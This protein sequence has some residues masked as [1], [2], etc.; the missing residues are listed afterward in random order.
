MW[1]RYSND[2]IHTEE[3]QHSVLIDMVLIT[4]N[5][6]WAFDDCGNRQEQ[7]IHLFF[8]GPNCVSQL[9]TATIAHKSFG[10]NFQ[11]DEVYHKIIFLNLL[12][13][14]RVVF[15]LSLLDILKFSFKTVN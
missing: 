13:E 8:E 9:A 2:M 15:L 12:N 7:S 4:P 3:Q 6:E 1:K 14:L 5:L 10:A 11:C